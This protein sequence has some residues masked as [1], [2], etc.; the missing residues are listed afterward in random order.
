VSASNFQLDNDAG[1]LDPM[2]QG[3]DQESIIFLSNLEGSFGRFWLRDHILQTQRLA[4]ATGT[5]LR[6]TT[7]YGS[8][9]SRK[10]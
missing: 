5:S 7:S 8:T 1:T 3:I 9:L 6:Y 2:F 4:N 10:I